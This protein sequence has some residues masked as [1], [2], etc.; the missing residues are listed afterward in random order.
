MLFRS[1]NTLA[2]VVARYQPTW[3][4]LFHLMA[5]VA[6]LN[7]VL[8]EIVIVS[9]LAFGMA[10]RGLVWRGFGTV[11]PR[12]RAP[13]TATLAIGA[14]TTALVLVVPFQHL[15]EWTSGLTLAVLA[16]VNASLWRLQRIA[17]RTDL[18]HAVPR[19]I[20]ATGALACV[21]LIAAQV[22]RTLWG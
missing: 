3:G 2:N 17:P 8:I 13:V 22:A 12:T 14:V 5:V 11:H 19:W 18:A 20:P 4:P 6:T 21:G 7:G 1:T 10:Q 15:V 9:R 16:A